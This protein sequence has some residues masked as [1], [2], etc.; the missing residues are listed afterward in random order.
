MKKNIIRIFTVASALLAFTACDKFLD[1]TSYTERNTSNFP[2]SE[3]DA[4]QLVTG[5]YATLNLDLRENPGT[6]YIMQANLC[7][8]DQYGGGGIDDAEAQAW[9]H[10][11]YNDMDA[12]A[13]YWTSCYSG[14]GR[15]NMAIANLD[16]VEDESLRNQLLGEA[17]ILRAWFYFELAQMFEEVP[18]VT[19]VPNSVAETSEYPHIGS[20]EEVYGL[21]AADLK[22]ACD[23]MPS[24][25]YGQ[26]LSGTGH[27]SRWVAEGLLARVYLFYTGFYSDKENKSITTLP[28][29]DLETFEISG[30]TV[31]KEYVVE[32]LEDCIKNS[33]YSLVPDYRCLWSYSNA[34]TKANYP[35]MAD[36]EESWY[37][38]NENPEQMFYIACAQADDKYNR[39]VLYL[40]LRTFDSGDYEPVFPM[41]KGY[42]FATVN[43]DLWN[44]WDADDIRRK[45]SIWSVMDEAPNPDGYQIG[46]ENQMEES[47]L[48]QKKT[49]AIACYINDK[50]FFE[51]TSSSLYYGNDKKDFGRKKCTT[52]FTL[53]RFADVLLMHAELTDGKVIYKGMDGMNAIRNRAKLAT[54]PYSVDALRQ[55]RRHEFAFEGIRWGDMRRYGKTYCIAALESQLNQDIYNMG[56]K[57]K[58]KDQGAG[59]RARYEATYGFRPYPQTEISLSN[60]VLTQR[61]GWDASSALFTSW[62]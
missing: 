25:P 10:L 61:P 31:S 8:D 53:M 6:C 3:E 30:Q 11:M 16:K 59:Y 22:K 29:M 54:I 2:A 28:L 62:K 39:M 40:G 13:D 41:N 43:P 56:V 60:G 58:M 19:N 37:R 27:V 12:Q 57:T 46:A 47:L 36:C 55:E 20:Y 9:D 44:T 35:F 24:T 15:A 26:I 23:I 33:G 17:H 4:L 49:Q 51:F 5:I 38:D 18:L 48:W 45:G 42:G 7:S 34:A 32:K 52:D 50:W 21:I 14:I 1:T